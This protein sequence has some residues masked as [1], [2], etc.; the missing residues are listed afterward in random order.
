MIRFRSKNPLPAVKCFLVDSA[1]TTCFGIFT[2]S[3]RW[4]LSSASM[5]MCWKNKNSTKSIFQKIENTKSFD[6]DIIFRSDH[7]LIFQQVVFR[8]KIRLKTYNISTEIV[9][10]GDRSL[11]ELS[12]LSR[13]QFGRLHTGTG[14]AHQF[15]HP[16]ICLLI[17]FYLRTISKGLF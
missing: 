2:T 1:P 14:F 15:L 16:G 10:G 5:I 7:F 12:D 13:F 4:A 3:S 6:F 9:R 11:D 17:F 8:K